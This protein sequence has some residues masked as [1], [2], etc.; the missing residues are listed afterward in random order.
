MQQA[1]LRK[2]VLSAV[3]GPYYRHGKYEKISCLASRRILLSTSTGMSFS[4][5]TS[6][7]MT[8]SAKAHPVTPQRLPKHQSISQSFYRSPLTPSTSPYTPISLHSLDSTGSS[9]LTTPD[10]SGIG[11]RKRLAFS[12]LSPEVVRNASA[13][14]DKSLADIAEN[15]RSR[16]NENNQKVSYAP[17][18]NSHYAGDESSVVSDIDDSILTTEEALLAAPFLSTHRRL[19]SMPVISNRPRA[20]SHAPL[21]SLHGPPVSP[22]T[23]RTV[24][25]T[26]QA[27]SPIQH[28]RALA[29]FSQSANLMSTPPPN[30]TLARQLKL[31]GSL[32][33]PPQP[34][35]REALGNIAIG[36]NHNL[37]MSLTLEPD[38]SLDLFDIGENDFEYEQDYQGENSFS[39]DLQSLHCNSSF[40]YPS[41]TPHARQ[42]QSQA[43]VQAG[44]ADPFRP[45]GTV[46]GVPP[47]MLNGIAESVEHHFHATQQQP[48]KSFFDDIHQSGHP[49]FTPVGHHPGQYNHVMPQPYSAPAFV[50]IP[51]PQLHSL[52]P[53]PMH[54][55]PASERPVVFPAVEVVTPVPSPETAPTDCSV[56]LASNPSSLA[57]LQPCGHPLCSTCLTSALNIVG[58]K[59]MQCAVCKRSVADFKLIA[60]M[61][62]GQPSSKGAKLGPSPSGLTGKSFMDTLSSS[63]SGSII[64]DPDSANKATSGDLDSAFE[65]GLDFGELRASTPRL[66][67]QHDRLM[68][69]RSR[70]S[71]AGVGK[72]NARKDEDNV[73][74]RI[75]NVPWDITPSQ[76]VKWLQQPVER[77]HVL[78]DGKGKT[79]SHA[80]VEVDNAAIAGAIL[81]GEAATRNLLGRK[82][83]GSVLG[84]GR[85]ARGVTITRS[86]QQELMSDLF[87]HWRGNF[88]GSRPSLA[89]LESERIIG[90]LERGLLT[91]NEISGLLHLINEPDSHFLKVPSLPFHSL[92]SILS[93]FPTDVDSRVFWSAGIR[94]RLF[95]ATRAAIEALMPRI[96][97]AKEDAA[98][99]RHADEEHTMDLAADLLRAGLECKAFTTQ[100]VQAMMALA[101]AHSLPLPQA[102][103]DTSRNSNGSSDAGSQS[104]SSAPRTP[105]NLDHST[106]SVAS[107]QQMQTLNQ[108]TNVAYPSLDEL[109]KEFGVDA[110]V[111]QALAQRLANL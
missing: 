104:E 71:V 53:T 2:P 6:P 89:G 83:R 48:H 108:P 31:K 24:K 43:F 59:D 75:D 86:G 92:I 105:S 3:R 9:T 100:Q 23:S 95:D 56:C 109:A 42:A 63:P 33:D 66:E 54:F 22:V 67:Q 99:P 77:V 20:Q 11:V 74:L 39:Q 19:S 111:V 1:P 35:R 80:Y 13:V 37:N 85:R 106:S 26:S 76:I 41:F 58:E 8:R 107:T 110:Q 82:E 44:F 27:S 32:T 49:F 40:G 81:R 65:F 73:V 98:K 4:V 93:K 28:R 97:K 10:N 69:G 72:R 61:P 94:D 84:R 62:K 18:D 47:H 64:F 52:Q 57:I 79:L 51:H 21:P 96:Q 88:D 38:T 103:A 91:D 15:W 68:D 34:R 102:H 36:S 70:I 17:Q 46:H 55:K 45:V 5:P 87:P 60:G 7:A 14:K 90:A 30:R 78:L 29:S 25:N 12:A 101:E 50:P 16:V